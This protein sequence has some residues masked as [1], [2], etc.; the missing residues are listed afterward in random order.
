MSNED[1]DLL[2][3]EIK[4]RKSLPTTAE[5]STEIV[6]A[7]VFGVGK[8]IDEVKSKIVAKAVDKIQDE[9][10]IEKHSEEIAKIGDEALEVE[11][12][13]ER[14]K[15]QQ[16]DA[17]NKAVKQEIKNRLIVLKAE[18]K[19]LEREQK[20]LLKEQEEDHKRRNDQAKWEKYKDKLTK[21]KYT[22]VPNF[23]ILG[24]LLFFDGIKSFFDGLGA[25]ST[26]IVKAFKWVLIFAAIII[27]I[28]GIPITRE[29]VLNLLKFK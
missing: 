8:A 17:D 10:I 25:V 16:A 21:M 28:M 4:R 18:A 13:R 14:L 20:Q 2:E 1:L 22:Y 9:K 7:E 3:E 24:M 5:S 6:S 12:E 11:A 26:A 29:W 27:V 23:F 15:V 19:R